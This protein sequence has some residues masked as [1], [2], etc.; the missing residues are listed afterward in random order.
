M[1]LFF[2][3]NVLFVFIMFFIVFFN[4]FLFGG[5]NGSW[6][7]LMS[8]LSINLCFMSL[9]M[10]ILILMSE[11]FFG[12]KVLAK[13]TVLISILFFG[14]QNMLMFFF[15]FELVMVPVLMMI[16]YYGTQPEKTSASYYAL[17][18]TSTFSL[19]FLYVIMSLESWPI[20]IFSSSIQCLIFLGLFM[21]KSPLFMM[22]YWLPKAHVEAPTSA[23]MLLAG[24]LLKVGV[25]GLMKL[26]I[27]LSFTSFFLFLF[28]FMGVFMGSHI[29]SYSSESKVLAANSSV[30]HINLCLFSL[31][32][33][34]LCLNSGSYLVSLSHGY[35]S[36]LLFYL[37]GEMYHY[38]GSR[39]LYYMVGVTGYSGFLMSM[40][41]L[42]FLSNAGVPPMLSFW[43]ELITIM[44][45]MNIYV[46]LLFFLSVYF[47][48]SFYYSIYL[49]MHVSSSGSS[50]NLSVY[51]SLY[52]LLTM[53]VL[54]NVLVFML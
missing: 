31:S 20:M 47:F 42:I 2:S 54:F 11:R 38:N 34:N 17:I 15:M 52:C 39:M 9:F 27:Y 29:A 10:L 45:L 35:I 22:H 49:M 4:S 23:S 50:M 32:L 46:F 6:F 41:G 8:W 30:T 33:I 24:L 1:L 44:V 18:Y 3:F 51:V 19:P 28:S 7:Y 37:V 25:Y 43:G 12:L 48:F 14:S 53:I 40:M 21:V 36:T 16:V 5:W 13:F 26:I